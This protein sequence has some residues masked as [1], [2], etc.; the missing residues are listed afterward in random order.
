M[1]NLKKP[2]IS[3][4]LNF[5]LSAYSTFVSIWI[6]GPFHWTKY[7]LSFYLKKTVLMFSQKLGLI[8]KCVETF[9]FFRSLSCI[10]YFFFFFT[11]FF[12]S[13]TRKLLSSFLLLVHIRRVAKLFRPPCFRPQCTNYNASKSQVYIKQTK[14]RSI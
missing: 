8:K 4:R 9:R 1:T 7:I 2:C 5:K 6:N 14:N 12:I 3:T 11:F 10:L 13:H